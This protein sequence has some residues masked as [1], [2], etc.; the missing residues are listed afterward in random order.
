MKITAVQTG[1]IETWMTLHARPLKNVEKFRIEVPVSCFL[2]ECSKGKILFDAGQKPLS[3]VQ[4]RRTADYYVKISPEETAVRK[5]EAMNISPGDLSY[6]ILSHTHGDH[7]DGL[8]DFPG[9]KVIVRKQAEPMPEKFRNSFVYIDSEF[10]V[11]GDR[12]VL[13]IPTP[14]HTP[15]HQSLLI[16]HDDGSRE[17][18]LGDVVYIPEALDYEPEP[19]EYIQR[20]AY[21]DSI[22][23][24]RAM[25]D[26][27]IKI[28]FSHIPFH[29]VSF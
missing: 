10:D 24:V 1:T 18:L 25:R 20:P 27:G 9:V 14:G 3:E 4:D 15:E 17:L 23:K 21:F 7:V 2:V 8:E 29:P 5:L 19:E 11:F 16:S 6:I 28:R 26:S 13:C 22:R 12:S